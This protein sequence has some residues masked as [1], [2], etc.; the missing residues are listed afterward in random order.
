MPIGEF[1]KFIG[2]PLAA[3]AVFAIPNSASA[4][5]CADVAACRAITKSEARLACFDVTSARLLSAI[6]AEQR[7]VAHFGTEP[8]N[9]TIASNTTPAERGFG[10]KV[11]SIRSAVI[12]MDYDQG[13][14][15]F[16]LQN[17][18]VWKSEDKRLLTLIGGG[19]DSVRID[20][21]PVG[22]LLHFNG[23]FFGLAVVRSQ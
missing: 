20:K 2:R 13:K 10:V 15:R 1:I 9:S 8:R 22:Y 23:S 12:R 21:T 11:S 3:L 7:D 6:S 14:P 4:D 17:G 18:Q 19:R 16:S 5:A